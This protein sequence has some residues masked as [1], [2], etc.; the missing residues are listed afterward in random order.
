MTKP[1]EEPVSLTV[2]FPRGIYELL[3]IRTDV[4]GRSLTKEVIHLIKLGL[5][6]GIEADTRALSQ[7]SQHLPKEIEQP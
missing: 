2:Y 3:K 4:T 7:L 6:Y 1:Q 5:K